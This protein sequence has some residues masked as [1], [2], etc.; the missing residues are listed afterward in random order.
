M[1]LVSFVLYSTLQATVHTYKFGPTDLVAFADYVKY[2]TF[3]IKDDYPNV[4]DELIQ[5]VSAI[6]IELKTAGEDAQFFNAVDTLGRP[7]NRSVLKAVTASK[8]AGHF[9][10]CYGSEILTEFKNID[11][12]YCNR[13]F[14]GELT[15]QLGRSHKAVGTIDTSVRY[16]GLVASQSKVK[17]ESIHAWE[18]SAEF[19][20]NLSRGRLQQ[21]LY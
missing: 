15:S 19:D 4:R 8:I 5:G 10:G 17:N 14:V 20:P 12:G 6:K 2:S 16:T 1:S 21:R 3:V 7:N 18:T 9:S 11:T 13:N